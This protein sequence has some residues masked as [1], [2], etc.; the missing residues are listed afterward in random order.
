MAPGSGTSIC[1][2]WKASRGSPSRSSRI[3]QASMV[4]GMARDPTV[5]SEPVAPLDPEEREQDHSGQQEGS[6]AE[7]QEVAAALDVIDEP[8]EVLA[9][10]PG[11]ERP[12]DEQRAEDRDPR[13]D[14][15]QAVRVGV[16]VR[17][18]ERGEVLALAVE[19]AGDLGQVV[20]DVAQVLAGVA[21]LDQ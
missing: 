6:D 18:G 20:A 13:G 8:L 12:Q 4:A 5:G 14:G 19:L 1:S 17:R 16:E 21:E 11:D 2:I 9:E 10:E 7:Q 15:V 3:T